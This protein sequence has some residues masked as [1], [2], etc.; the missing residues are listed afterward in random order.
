MKRSVESYGHAELLIAIDV[1]ASQ[2]K[3]VP[4][5]D[6]TIAWDDMRDYYREAYAA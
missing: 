5:P 4:W 3:K 2:K 1:G 6:V